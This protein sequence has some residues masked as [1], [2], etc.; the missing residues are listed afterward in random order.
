MSKKNLAAQFI[1]LILTISICQTGE[2]VGEAP[3]P[4][5][6]RPD[7]QG[8]QIVFTSEADL[9][10]ASISTGL[11]RRITRHPGMETNAHF[12]PDGRMLGFNAQYDGAT[13]FY[14]M[15]VNDGTPKRLT[16]DPTGTRVIGW[17]PDGTHVLF[18]SRRANPE[19]RSRLWKVPA[20]GGLP[21]LIPI[22]RADLADM[23][24]DGNRLAYV[25]ISGE[26]LRWKQYK[27]GQAD[28]I[29]IT[30]ISKRTFKRIT[31]YIGIDTTPAWAGDS[32]YFI[33]ERQGLA[34]LYRLNPEDSSITPITRYSDAEARYPS[35][36]GKTVVFQH[37]DGLALYDIAANKVKELTLH[38][39]T[40]RIHARKK[41]VSASSFLNSV[42]IGPTGKRV[43]IEAR[44]QLVSLPVEEG[45]SRILAP[46]SG[47]RS[48]SPSWSRDG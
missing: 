29:W 3:H 4:F 10:I 37:G 31:K 24:P 8:E 13:D 34:N 1:V 18:L 20:R 19:N 21:S 27:G 48:K 32:I 17:T 33:S 47:S 11:A 16:W 41:R 9:W 43:I 44:G 30:D 7:V 14:V 25:P 22:P 40:D 26:R 23:A 46:L 42:A 36:D 5:L 39:D 2:A 45:A 35:S 15:P 12:S 6:R 38:M 28:D